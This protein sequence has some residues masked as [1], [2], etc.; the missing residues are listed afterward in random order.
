MKIKVKTK[1]DEI[2]E[3]N[4]KNKNKID[5]FTEIVKIENTAKNR[6]N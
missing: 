5:T 2:N 6:Q 3:M 4:I 1:L